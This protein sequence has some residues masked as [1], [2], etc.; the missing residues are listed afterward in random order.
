MCSDLGLCRLERWDSPFVASPGGPSARDEDSRGAVSNLHRRARAPHP[1]RIL[2]RIVS[3]GA[4]TAP[5][6]GLRLG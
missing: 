2:G 5:S 4:K 6:I 3:G 1:A